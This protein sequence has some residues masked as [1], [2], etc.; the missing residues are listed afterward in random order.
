MGERY[1]ETIYSDD[2]VTQ[3]IGATALHPLFPE[4]ALALS[5]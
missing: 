2:W 4:I 1:L 3:R 5:A